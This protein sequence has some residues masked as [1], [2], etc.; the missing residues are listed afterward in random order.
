[1]LAM[2][3]DSVTSV[4]ASDTSTTVTRRHTHGDRLADRHLKHCNTHTDTDTYRQTD[5][6]TTSTTVTH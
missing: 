1:M 4:A 5:T 6:E 3:D 2:N